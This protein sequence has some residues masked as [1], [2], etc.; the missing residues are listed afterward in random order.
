MTEEIMDL[1]QKYQT[2]IGTWMDVLDH[3]SNY[4]RRVTRRAASSELLMYSICALAAKQ[5]S[6]VGEYSVWEPIAG[7]FYGQSLRLLIHDLNQLEARYDEVLVATILLSSYEL[8]AVPG[9]DYR[10]HLQGVSSLLQSHCLSS[11][12]TDLDRASFWIYARHDV[13]MA[14]INYC[15]SLIP[16][17]EWPAA[18]TSE[19]SE[20]DAAGNQVLWLLARVIELK[21]ASPANIEPDKRKQGLS[22]VAADVE[23]WWDNLSLTSHGL[24]S[25]ELSEDGLEKLWFCVQSAG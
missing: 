18:I 14:I 24:S 12:T 1:V 21:F 19:N 15:P 17:S 23:R 8:L 2:G 10:R 11:I 13:A 22:E 4:R 6:L 5:M 9:P 16:T 25:G 7:R 3:S 20:E